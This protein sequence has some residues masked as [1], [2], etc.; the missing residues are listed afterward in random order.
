[1]KIPFNYKA[2]PWTLILTIALVA[3]CL[4]FFLRGCIDQ[5]KETHTDV[6]PAPVVKIDYTDTL[7]I[8]RLAEARYQAKIDSIKRRESA[9]VQEVAIVRRENAKITAAYKKAKAAADT[10]GQLASA[11]ELV[12]I[13]E[14]LLEQING[15]QYRFDSVARYADSA[16]RQAKAE[17][18]VQQSIAI[19]AKAEAQS[20]SDA[21]DIANRNGAVLTGKL[22]SMTKKAKGGRFWT[23]L[24]AGTTGAA[25]I[26]S[27]LK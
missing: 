18:M 17:T 1:M 19:Q 3:V 26:I 16:I 20:F 25:A 13:N 9:A 23:R 10:V 2:W 11:S 4:I 5:G 12:G 21:L 7:A 14:F 22:N 6:K 24:F 27:I 15:S 8:I